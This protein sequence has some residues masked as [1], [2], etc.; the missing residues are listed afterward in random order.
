MCMSGT[1]AM[2]PIN[3]GTR[4]DDEEFDLWRR[5]VALRVSECAQMNK[6]VLKYI[7]DESG[8]ENAP[9]VTASQA[10]ILYCVRHREVL[11]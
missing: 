9:M 10:E 3:E 8:E 1:T 4:A 2:E 7:V 6:D 11:A 5:I